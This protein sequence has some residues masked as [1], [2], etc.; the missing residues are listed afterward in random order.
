MDAMYD[1]FTFDRFGN[2]IYQD[3]GDKYSYGKNPLQYKVLSGNDIKGNN[4]PSDYS[5]LNAAELARLG[6]D[7]EQIK[8]VLATMNP[9]LNQ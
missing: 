7:D 2:V 6:L 3:T 1:N 8:G 9:N 4:V 5:Y